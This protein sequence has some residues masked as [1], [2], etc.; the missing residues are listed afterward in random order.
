MAAGSMIGGADFKAAQRA[1]REGKTKNG[2]AE[3]WELVEMVGFMC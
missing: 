3:P 2:M 1:K